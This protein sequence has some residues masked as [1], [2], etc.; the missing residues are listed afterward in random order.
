MSQQNNYNQGPTAIPVPAPPTPTVPITTSNTDAKLNGAI[1]KG[2]DSFEI[3]DIVMESIVEDIAD[4]TFDRELRRA[5]NQSTVQTSFKRA[6]TAKLVADLALQKRQLQFQEMINVK[7]ALTQ[8]LLRYLVEEVYQ[9]VAELPI[10]GEAKEMFKIRLQ[11]RLRGFEDRAEK[12][13]KKLKKNKEVDVESTESI[14][15]QED[16]TDIITI[17]E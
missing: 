7:G 2:Q 13:L 3:V 1:T 11:K 8:A 9:T 16:S 6:T 14:L 4:L 12:K 10:D 15:M 5:A 17:E